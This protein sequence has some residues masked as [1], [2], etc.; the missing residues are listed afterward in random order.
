VG[1]EGYSVGKIEVLDGSDSIVILIGNAMILVAT[2]VN[3]FFAGLLSV[4]VH[5]VH[6]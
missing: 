4:S 6:E 3:F 1:C 5:E 2:F